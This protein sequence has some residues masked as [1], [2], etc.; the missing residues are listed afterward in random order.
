M[1]RIDTHLGLASKVRIS[2][3]W[4]LQTR[5]GER[6]VIDSGHPV[7][8]LTLRWELWRAGVRGPGDLD[9]V[10]LTHRHSDHAGNAAWLRRT[11]DCP[12]ICHED[13][14]PYLTEDC[15]RPIMAEPQVPFWARILCHI[16][17]HFPARVPVDETFADGLWKHGLRVFHAPGHTDGSVLIHHEDTGI[18]FSGD[19]ILTG[20][21]PFRF[22]ERLNLAYDEFSADARRA[23]ASVR[24]VIDDFPPVATLCSGHGPCVTDFVDQKIRALANGERFCVDPN[25][26]HA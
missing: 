17:D 12:V 23:H 9:A 15:P 6:F 26:A 7:E 1:Q 25:L 4:L 19:N 20:P 2:N 21:P 22:I 14:A 18:L 3:V 13:D 10:I 8:R 5:S 24:A 16:E 11:F